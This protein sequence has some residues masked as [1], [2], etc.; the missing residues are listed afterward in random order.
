[1]NVTIDITGHDTGK[2]VALMRQLGPD[3]STT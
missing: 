2:I 3:S 1:M